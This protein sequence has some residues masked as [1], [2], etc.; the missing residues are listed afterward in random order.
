V[1]SLI[2]TTGQVVELQGS[3][4]GR[5]GKAN[6]YLEDA[7]DWISVMVEAGEHT[8]LQVA[9]GEGQGTHMLALNVSGNIERSAL[10]YYPPMIGSD[11]DRNEE[12]NILVPTGGTEVLLEG[13]NFGIG[14][15]Y[16]LKMEDLNENED[17][18]EMEYNSNFPVA[19][20]PGSEE[21]VEFNHTHIK[22]KSPEGQNERNAP[23][24]LTLTVAGQTSKL[25]NFDYGAPR[26]DH[27]AM[28]FPDATSAVY[29]YDCVTE[30]NPLM[31]DCDRNAA[32]GCGLNT[33]GG[34]TLAIMGENFGDPAAGVQKVFFGED[35]LTKGVGGAVD[36]RF[37]S[38][39][40]I[41]IRVPPGVGMDI[42]VKVMV[43]DRVTN[44]ED[45]SCVRGPY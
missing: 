42:G 25:V 10:D 16:V 26:I 14:V 31:T 35:E 13:L 32:G 33:E 36:V 43:G 2:P 4:F 6:A 37:V 17:G 24:T 11:E 23:L 39:N 44:T 3:Y 12:D 27:L 5:E 28:C 1:P 21:I 34:Y 19:Y 45:F 41:N 30:M 18:N 15:D 9:V 40:Q 38:H 20:G 8:E 29:Q 22:F 7:R